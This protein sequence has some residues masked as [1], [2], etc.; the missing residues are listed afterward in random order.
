MNRSQSFLI[1]QLLL[2]SLT[3]S[4]KAEVGSA[5]APGVAPAAQTISVSEVFCPDG[6]DALNKGEYIR[7]EKIFT[8]ALAAKPSGKALGMLKAG[9]A[10]S[11]M[12]Q[13]KLSNSQSEYKKALSLVNANYGAQSI[14]AAKVLDGMGWLYFGQNKYDKA[15]QAF[16][17]ELEIR[18]SLNSDKVLLAETESNLGYIL[19]LQSRF[20]EASKLYQEALKELESAPGDF[21]VAK[22]DVMESLANALMKQG[23][24]NE[25]AKYFNMSVQ[26][27]SAQQAVFGNYSP[28]A[29][30]KSV[31]FRFF[32]DAPNC[33]YSTAGGSLLESLTANGVTVEVSVVR[34][35][36]DI[37]KTTQANVTITNRSGQQI[38]VLTPQ[39]L[40]VTLSPKYSVSVPINGDQLANKVEKK[41]ESKAKWIRFWG[42][43][44]TTSVTSTYMGNGYRGGYPGGY[45]PRGF[46]YGYGAPII[47]NGNGFS[48][49]TTQIPDWEARA[50]AVARANE[51]QQKTAMAADQLRSN[52]LGASVVPNGG[53][54]S[55][56][57]NF[58]NT[59]F[60][61]ALIQ[62]PIGNSWF[63]FKFDRTQI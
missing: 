63:E 18:R 51:V 32:K 7:A 45:Y 40:L 24:P 6:Q 13:G 15:E 21:S 1:G 2:L 28:K 44:A 10:E 48:T 54:V 58:D 12:W 38:S 3:Q 56:L 39:P 50:R 35:P 60:D 5:S 52:A 16:R 57:I 34:K 19:E 33:T 46:G 61:Q 53:A 22:A 37:V 17:Q 55:G 47:T 25:A 49:M 20:L 27:K 36:S 11:L 62:L 23:N 42:E 9:L 41:G 31:Y 14:E 30:L 26:I 43:G 8:D 59:K 4:A 29:L